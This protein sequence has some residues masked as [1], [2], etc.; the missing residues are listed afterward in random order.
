MT[1]SSSPMY[2]HT[3][4]SCGIIR[5]L[6]TTSCP[7][8]ATHSTHQKGRDV[9]CPCNRNNAPVPQQMHFA[10]EALLSYMGKMVSTMSA[11]MLSMQGTFK[12]CLRHRKKIIIPSDF[13]FQDLKWGRYTRRRKG[14]YKCMLP[15]FACFPWQWVLSWFPSL[16]PFWQQKLPCKRKWGVP[17]Q[18][19][20]H[21][22][23]LGNDLASRWHQQHRQAPNNLA[24]PL[25]IP[26]CCELETSPD[27]LGSLQTPFI[28]G[29]F[30]VLWLN[31]EQLLCLHA[32]Q[33]GFLIEVG[34]AGKIAQLCCVQPY[35][36]WHICFTLGVL[37][38]SQ[39]LKASACELDR[40]V[41]SHVVDLGN[42]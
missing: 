10:E 21:Q 36:W 16:S 20:L 19:L 42:N 11:S 7:R 30:H 27:Y 35:P 38:W 17:V 26:F 40:A 4:W 39:H 2:S 6:S 41:G 32:T 8:H 12:G 15:S 22:S 13:T 9:S 29:R 37:G 34:N 28:L 31:F 18:A 24:Q 5:R 1:L 23:W 14:L 25:Q 3:L 33:R